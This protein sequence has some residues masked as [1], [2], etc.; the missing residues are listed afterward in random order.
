MKSAPII[1]SK[2]RRRKLWVMILLGLLII[3]AGIAY[4][5]STSASFEYTQRDISLRDVIRNNENIKIDDT[6]LLKK[7]VLDSLDKLGGVYVVQ[8][9]ISVDEKVTLDKI[10]DFQER[11]LM[12]LGEQKVF[13]DNESITY[14][15][16]VTDKSFTP[17]NLLTGERNLTE[18]EAAALQRS[19][20]AMPLDQR[21]FLTLNNALLNPTAPAFDI[22]KFGITSTIVDQ[23]ADGTCWAF[24]SVAA[25]EVSYQLRRN[26]VIKASEQ[27]VLDCSGV[28]TDQ[29]GIAYDVF[30]WMGIG[31][32]NLDNNANYPY[33]GLIRY[34][35]H[36]APNTDF[37]AAAS[38]LVNR[39]PRVIAA[40]NDIKAAICKYGSVVSSVY[41]T[42]RWRNIGMD[43]ADK[44]YI[45]RTNYREP[46][47]DLSSNHS[48]LIIGWDDAKHAWLVKNSWGTNWGVT[49]GFGNQRGYFWLDYQSCNIGKRAAWVL[50]R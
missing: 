38:D 6:S 10:L 43:F 46:N 19:L 17:I 3:I 1:K 39:N 14:K 11:E 30:R 24:A 45:D 20:D 42:R 33:T 9:S 27:H 37:Y 5:F 18:T 50:A 4:Y 40:V 28:A 26:R 8:D 13:Y 25:Y 15:F 36:S 2:K 41:V 16:E 23:G 22:R 29:G 21:P 44:P 12:D 35:M 34:C 7:V 48:V 47:N 49:C 32:K 31:R